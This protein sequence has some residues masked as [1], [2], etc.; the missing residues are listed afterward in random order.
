[1]LDR[2]DIELVAL[3]IAIANK[4]GE[5]KDYVDQVVAAFNEQTKPLNTLDIHQ[6]YLDNHIAP[7]ATDYPLI[8][9]PIQDLAN[10]K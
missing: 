9:M 4:H 1:M 10:I 2:A 6:S 5:P 3:V 7:P 8:A